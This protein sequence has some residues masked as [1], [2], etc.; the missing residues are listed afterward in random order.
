MTAT[1]PVETA[2]RAED[3]AETA[4]VA[5]VVP[6]APPSPPVVTPPPTAPVVPPAKVPFK[7][8]AY[9]AADGTEVLAHLYDATPANVLEFAEWI[10]ADNLS[11]LND[12]LVLHT[13]DTSTIVL[14][15]VWVVSASGAYVTL[16]ETAFANGYTPSG[17]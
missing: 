11:V 1:D 2:D 14:P 9:K 12:Q 5:P 3:A 16:T 13:G 6:A 8:G 15:G 10:G 7:A 4:P 17:H